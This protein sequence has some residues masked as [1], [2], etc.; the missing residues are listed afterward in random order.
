MINR[1]NGSAVAFGFHAS[2]GNLELKPL[3]P[4][5]FAAL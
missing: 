1:L 5:A 4:A 3:P 2:S